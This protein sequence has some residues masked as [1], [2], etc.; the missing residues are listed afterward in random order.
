MGTKQCILQEALRLFSRKG[1]DA[2]SVE[3]I[4][5]AVGI[6]APS[7]YKHYK[8]KQDIFEAIFE[9]T[10]RRYDAFTDSISVHLPDSGRDV[11]TFEAITAD[12]LVEKVQSL[13]AYSLHDEFV[14]RF[15]RM[16]T[17][18]Q[19]RSPELSALY[20]ERYVV[21][22]QRYHTELFRRMMDAGVLCAEDPAVLAR[23]YDA[24]ILLLLG[25]CDRH[26]E[27]EQ[28]AME[29]LEAHVRLFYRTFNRRQA[30]PDGGRR[31][32]HHE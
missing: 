24:P 29:A 12:V 10:A 23:M 26:P 21:Q 11:D 15:R 7:L 19:F 20:S 18:E 6:R 1:Y 31:A 28:A 22:I 3:Q 25:E 9:E 8:G 16:M 14:S 5:D 17:I 30:D 32:I 13:V 2:V 27:Q 4:A